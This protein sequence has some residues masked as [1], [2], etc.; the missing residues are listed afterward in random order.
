VGGK[1]RERPY[2]PIKLEAKK[3]LRAVHYYDPQ[4]WKH[5]GK[6]ARGRFARR[7]KNATRPFGIWPDVRGGWTPKQ[8]QIAIEECRIELDRRN[9]ADA[10]AREK[11][12]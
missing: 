8:K 4:S 6:R 11:K 1:H 3:M 5:R 12:S 10:V 7:T 2:A 9:K